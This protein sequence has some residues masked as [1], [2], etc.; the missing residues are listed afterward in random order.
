M[1]CVVV[2]KTSVEVEQQDLFMLRATYSSEIMNGA[3]LL[4]EKSAV[5]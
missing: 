1:L 3:T 2:I 4:K 5:S